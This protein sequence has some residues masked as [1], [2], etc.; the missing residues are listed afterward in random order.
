MLML[1]VCINTFVLISGYYG[2]NLRVKSFLNLTGMV[3]FYS[4]LS[5]LSN[6]VIF[7][8]GVNVNYI[9]SAFLPISHNHF[10]WFISCYLILMLLSPLI[11]R[12]LQ[13]LSN[14]NILLIIGILVY[15]N[16]ITGWLFKNGINSNG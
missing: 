1:G 11:N 7:W 14:Q 12:G 3:L 10:Y 16:C 2:I 4:F 8:G 5:S 9:V 6:I 15:I 13:A